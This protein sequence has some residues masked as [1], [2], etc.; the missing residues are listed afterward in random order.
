[1]NIRPYRLGELE[2]ARRNLEMDREFLHYLIEHPD[3]IAQIPKGCYLVI[4]P[5]DD[6]ELAEVNLAMATESAAK[7]GRPVFC[8]VKKT[9]TK[10]MQVAVFEFQELV[11]A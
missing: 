3:M 5:E 2:L 11:A 4:L 6:P 8:V 9:Q 7:E 10:Q 1:M